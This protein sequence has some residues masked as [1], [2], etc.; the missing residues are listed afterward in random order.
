M[1]F[2]LCPDNAHHLWIGD[3]FDFNECGIE[4]DDQNRPIMSRLLK[5]LAKV[6]NGEIKNKSIVGSA[7][8]SMD[9]SIHL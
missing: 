8:L 3:E 7:F 1:L 4:V 5:W 6:G 9:L 2:L